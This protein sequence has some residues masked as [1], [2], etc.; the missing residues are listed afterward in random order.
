M[1]AEAF[2]SVKR[3]TRPKVL[4]EEMLPQVP[5]RLPPVTVDRPC[6]VHIEGVGTWAV[7]LVDGRPSVTPGA[8]EDAVGQ[9]HLDRRALREVVAGALR[10][11]GLVVMER[12]GRPRQVPDLS[13]LKVDVQRLLRCAELDGSVAVEVHDREYDDVYRFTWTFGA[14][15][16][17]TGEVTTTVRVDADAPIDWVVQRMEPLQLLKAKGVRVDGDLSLPMKALRLLFD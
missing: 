17:V 12:L 8:A 14:G 6:N 1:D 2:W 16:P 10:D 3:S 5:V 4:L 9:L 7:Q 11:R 13:R 15:E